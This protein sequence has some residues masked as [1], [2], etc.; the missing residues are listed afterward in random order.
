MSLKSLAIDLKEKGITVLALHPGWVKT[1]MGG[2]NAQ[3]STATSVSGLMK[4]LN[5]AK[6]EDSGKFVGYDGSPIPW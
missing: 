6:L 2:K 3:I 1:D 5:K 4:I